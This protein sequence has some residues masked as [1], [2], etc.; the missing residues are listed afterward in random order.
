MRI[1]AM[2]AIIE[3]NGVPPNLSFVVVYSGEVLTQTDY[4][5]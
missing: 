4:T 1:N 3:I 5:K 2:E